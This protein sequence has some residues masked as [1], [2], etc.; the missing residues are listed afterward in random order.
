VA[1]RYLTA[2]LGASR[3]DRDEAVRRIGF[4]AAE[5]ARHGGLVLCCPVAPHAAARATARRLAQAAG[6]D[7][8]LAHVSTPRSV[9]EERD[10]RV[11]AMRAW[12]GQS[13]DPTDGDDYEVPVDA[14][15]V[16]D[17]SV[18]SVDESVKI[19][20]DHLTSEGWLDRP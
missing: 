6:A 13:A 8:V 4:V 7:F 20:I 12:A 11:L 17:N 3:A 14:E 18:L 5:A 2:G 10:P 15:L 9:C 16:I 19:L 1:R